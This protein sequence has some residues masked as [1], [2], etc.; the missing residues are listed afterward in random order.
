MM[1]VDYSSFSVRTIEKWYKPSK[2]TP[3]PLPKHVV[4]RVYQMQCQIWNADLLFSN[5]TN[6]L[7]KHPYHFPIN[8]LSFMHIKHSVRF[9]M[10]T[11]YLF[12]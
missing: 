4:F 2:Q 11:F 8:M 3:I 9:E 7:S 12:I 5:D 10:L 1:D 6:R